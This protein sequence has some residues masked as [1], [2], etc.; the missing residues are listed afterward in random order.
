MHAL[1]TLT[2]LIGYLIEAKCISEATSHKVKQ[3]LA[4]NQVTDVVLNKAPAASK[5]LYDI[6]YDV[7][8]I[9]YF[10]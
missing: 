9:F 10:R 8:I 3:Y 2:E 6:Y 1:L 4:E 5:Y 7:Y